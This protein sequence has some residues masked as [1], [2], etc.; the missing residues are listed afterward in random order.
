MRLVLYNLL[1]A[2]IL[3][4]AL[5]GRPAGTR[6]AAFTFGALLVVWVLLGLPWTPPFLAGLSCGLWLA[7][8]LR[9]SPPSPRGYLVGEK[10]PEM[11]LRRPP[12]A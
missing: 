6:P 11:F 1:S 9:P 4:W 2:V 10:G 3:V 5:F 12:D 8:L 7:V